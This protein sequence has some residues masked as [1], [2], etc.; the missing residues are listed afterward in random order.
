MT[1]PT[2]PE[3]L[4]ARPR[5]GLVAVTVVLPL[6]CWIWVIAMAR[7][8][9]GPMTGAS[10]WMMAVTW[11]WPRLLL[12]WAMWAAMMAAMMLPTMTPALLLYAKVMRRRGDEAAA[13]ARINLMASG[14]VLVW[15]LFS[16]GATVLQR[17]LANT[18]VLSMMM[19]PA[20]PFVAPVL[21]LIAAVYQWT[22]L[23]AACLHHCRSPLAL[24]TT[25]WREGTIGAFRMGVEQG[26]YCLGCCWA[27]M[28]LLFAGGV[29]NLA[30]ILA[31]TA[32]VAI[33]K[34]APF[35]QQSARVSGAVLAAMAIWLLVR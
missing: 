32:W 24:F 35:G 21:L 18:S 23:K 31:L 26:L 15:A 5:A 30:V 22:P 4:L 28:L 10:A 1:Q 7:D 12:L 16:V 2:V 20:S 3:T 11:D 17:V 29:M 6:A 34:V 9:Y 19:E 33:E 25:G 8:M 14:Y 13:V 27:Q